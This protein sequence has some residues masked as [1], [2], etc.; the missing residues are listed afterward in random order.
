M[1][2]SLGVLITYHNER[3]L[4]SRCVESLLSQ[5]D[6][7]DEILVYDDASVYDARAFLPAELH[8]HVVRGD[9]NKGPSHGRNS[10][11]R[12]SSTE[13]VHFH[14]ADDWFAPDWCL[15]VRG[16]L[17]PTI[18]AV[19][20]EV[21]SYVAGVLTHECVMDLPATASNDELLRFAILRVLLAPSGTYRRNLVE[22]LGGY[23]EGVWQSEDWDFHVRLAAARPRFTTIRKSLVAIDVRLA[24]RSQRR[25]E[26]WS[27]QLDAI[28]VLAR[29]LPPGVH[30]ELAEA[31]AHAS[32][33]LFRLGERERAARGFDLATGLGDPKY[34]G[35]PQFY[36]VL[37]SLV[38]PL[39]A[40]RI[41]ESYRRFVPAR[42]R[43]ISYQR[44]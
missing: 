31:A 13:F 44:Q 5:P 12:R 35:R 30:G 4:L 16:E 8:A 9:Y 41:S 22:S 27:S 19:F 10:L 42:L 43:A 28:S 1:K 40:E 38:S 36:R 33:E 6:P 25:S 7:P 24:G 11:L 18:D 15:T 23:R 32:G 37:A 14:D 17:T 26:V 3:H 29:E 2:P 21:A 20:T 34:S 39:F